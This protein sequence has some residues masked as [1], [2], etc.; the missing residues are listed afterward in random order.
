MTHGERTRA[1][2]M[3][4]VLSEALDAWIERDRQALAEFHEGCRKAD[5]EYEEAMAKIERESE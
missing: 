4:S 2:C 1:A 5:R 3:A